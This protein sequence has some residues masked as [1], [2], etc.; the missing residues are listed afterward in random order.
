VGKTKT[1]TQK[2]ARDIGDRIGVNWKRIPLEE[3]RMGLDVE[4]EH[5]LITPCTNVTYDEANMT[6]MIAL[7]HLNE[8]PDYYTVLRK[9]V[10]PG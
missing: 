6:G 3:F 9:Y 10:D 8:R 5:G 2:Q 1:F 7:A 4:M